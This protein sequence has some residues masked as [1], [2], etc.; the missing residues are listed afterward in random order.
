MAGDKITLSLT[1]LLTGFAVVFAVLLILIGIIKLYGTV[2]YHMQNKEKKKKKKKK[3]VVTRE[4]IEEIAPA[5]PVPAEAE[6]EEDDALIA[7][8]AAA[9]YS[10]YEPGSVRIKS[11][12][13]SAPR[14]NAWRSAGL[15]DNVRPF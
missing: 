8:I 14:A 13:K 2:I 12:R 11:V 9:V 1:I 5:A 10:M 3:V 4:E 6:P 7:V 15:M